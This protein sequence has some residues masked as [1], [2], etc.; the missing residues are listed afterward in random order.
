MSE[1]EDALLVELRKVYDEADSLLAG[2]TCPMTAE[3]CQF[4]ASGKEPF[5]T[6][7]ELAEMKRGIL[8]TGRRPEGPE[9]RTKE[10][11]R[12]KTRVCPMLSKDLK[13]TIYESRPLGCRTFF[14]HRALKG[15]K[16]PHQRWREMVR[17]IEDIAR[18]HKKQGE[19]GRPLGR[20]LGKCS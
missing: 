16:V 1:R 2:W 9:K 7:I 10:G 11:E 13:C 15:D 18:R 8:K 17:T 5:V 3:C 4:G 12:D 6:S 14:C 19:V 20:I